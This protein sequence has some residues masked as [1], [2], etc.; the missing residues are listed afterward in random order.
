MFGGYSYGYNPNAWILWAV[1]GFVLWA[2][3][4]VCYALG[5]SE[6]VK[7]R[8]PAKAWMA[9]VPFCS[10]MVLGQ[11][12]PELKV[13]GKDMRSL[14]YL[15]PVFSGLVVLGFIPIL[16]YITPLCLYALFIPFHM[17]IIR[18]YRPNNAIVL[19]VFYPVGYLLIRNQVMGKQP[20]PAPAP[21]YS[22]QPY[23]QQGYPQQQPYP[24]QQ[25][26]AQPSYPQQGYPQQQPYPQQQGYAQPAPQ[27]PGYGQPYPQQPGD[28][29]AYNPNNQG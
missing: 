26:Y 23:P 21:A 3:G 20:K 8:L 10:S 11:L 13:K 17:E 5:F 29:S 7:K 24:Q 16:Q 19:S 9:W 4:W 6:V 18:F 22:N 12:V 14:Q 27:Q 2:G 1:I 28:P 15:F 25:G